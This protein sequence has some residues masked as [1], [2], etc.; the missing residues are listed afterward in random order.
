M[1]ERLM[2]PLLHSQTGLPIRH[3]QHD[4]INPVQGAAMLLDGGYVGRQI[5]CQPL[6]FFWVKTPL[7]VA[8]DY[9]CEWK[10]NQISLF[11]LVFSKTME[12]DKPAGMCPAGL[13]KPTYS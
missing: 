10:S 9:V 5:L 8:W 3:V 1:E 12:K 2:G 11:C 6:A 13:S 7:Y 4:K